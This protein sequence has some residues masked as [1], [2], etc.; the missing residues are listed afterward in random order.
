MDNQNRNN[1]KLH[2]FN[3]SNRKMLKQFIMFP[4]M[5]HRNHKNWVPPVYRNEWNYFNP[6]KNHAFSYCDHVLATISRNGH[7]A[8]R[9]MGI[10]NNR[11]NSSLNESTARFSFFECIDDKVVANELMNLI[12]NWALT[13]KMKKILGPSGM[14]NQDPLGLLI[15]GYEHQPAI[16]TNYNYKYQV[17]FIEDRNYTTAVDYVVYKIDIPEEIPA[18][19]RR[20]FNRTMQRNNF[21]LLEFTKRSQLKDYIVPV[22]RLLNESYYDLHGYDMLDEKEMTSMGKQ[23]L[24][25]MDPKFIKI[26]SRGN[27]VAGFIIAMPNISEGLR[28]AKG[29]L[30]PFG[31]FKILKAAKTSSQ[32][33]LLI[34]GIKKKY[35][36]NGLDVMLGLKMIE[37]GQ[38]YGFKFIDSH[39][40][41]ENN[42][43][44][45]AEME[46]MGGKIYKRYRVYKK[47]LVKD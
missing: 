35:Q 34:G 44:I 14:Y 1:H 2:V 23:Y 33:D 12:E 22:L 19:Y 41:M 9:I 30:Y 8:G 40:E 37:T 13:K 20:I 42:H 5:L 15:D 25:I 17:R 43:K 39:L 18:F 24:A 28:K 16:A 32:L 27:E 10:I 46:K 21:H 31:L 47:D 36:G 11:Q 7:T 29:R 26:V 38:R 45:R 4:Q 6:A 3:V